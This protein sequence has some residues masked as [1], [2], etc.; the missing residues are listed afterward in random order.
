VHARVYGAIVL[1]LIGCAVA[2][3]PFW[4]WPPWTI[5]VPVA[6]GFL[7]AAG[8]VAGPVSRT[9]LRIGFAVAAFAAIFSVAWYTIG[10]PAWL[11]ALLE[12]VPAG[13]VM[14]D[15]STWQLAWEGLKEGGTTA[16]WTVVMYYVG[17]R[18]RTA[19]AQR[20]ADPELN[21]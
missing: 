2:A 18:A 15:Y 3:T 9:T 5:R 4:V 17:V 13:T 12:Q 10:S 19:L 16:L 8:V 7:V 20:A 6:A 14:L 11:P 21:R 1:S